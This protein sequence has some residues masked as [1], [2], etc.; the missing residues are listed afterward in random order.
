MLFLAGRLQFF[1]LTVFFKIL[2]VRTQIFSLSHS[3]PA[4]LLELAALV[5]VFGLVDLLSPRKGIA[6]FLVTNFFISTFLLSTVMYYNHFGRFL[7]YK[8]LSQAPLLKELGTSIIELFS[9]TYLFLYIDIV[10]IILVLWRMRIPRLKWSLYACHK[11][12]KSLV[13]TCAAL[14]LISISMTVYQPKDNPIAFAQGAGILNAQFYQAFTSFKKEEPKPMPSDALHQLN[15]QKIKQ[16]S[17]VSWPK[18]FGAARDKNLLFIQLESTQSFVVGLS[19]NDQEITPNL[20]KLINE[21]FY[22]PYFYSQVGQGN[23]SDAEFVTNTSIYPLELGL[24]STTFLGVEY[25]SL[26]R[27]LRDNDY[28]T[29]TFHPNRITFFRRDNLYPALGFNKYFDNT[30]YL[31]ED[32][33]GPWGSSDEVLFRKAIPILKEYKANNQ[34]FYASLITLSCHHPYIIPEAKRH[35]KL[36]SELQNTFIGNYLTAVHYQDFALGLF[37]RELKSAGLWDESMIVIFG[38]HFGISKHQEV[39]NQDLFNSILGRK[40]D[41]LDALH[42]PFAIRIPGL[43][44]KVVQTV[45]GHVDIFPTVANLLGIYLDDYLVFGQDILNH[46]N[47]LLG[48]R[49]YQPDGTFISSDIFYIAGNN[50]GQRIDNHEIIFNEEVLLQ[51]QQRIK[52]LLQLSDMYLDKLTKK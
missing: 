28:K 49:F 13:V 47:N 32:P 11:R 26:P 48:F 52:N 14:V 37:I 43:K 44:P 34:K 12:P 40:H 3:F 4:L 19:I 23:T 30:F 39:Q 2:F 51:E 1:T 9:L 33:V 46:D 15:I 16:I 10:L 29:I 27:L 18:Y 24:I 31:D 35:L 17:S 22:F 42:V 41:P 36:P 21:S 20:N 50:A 25:P 8:I 5:F 45:G 6:K 7:D 38:D